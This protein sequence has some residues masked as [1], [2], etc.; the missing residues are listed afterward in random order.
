MINHVKYELSTNILTV[1]DQRKLPD[2]EI[3]LNCSNGEEVAIAIENLTV[4]GAPLIGVTAAYG[5]L[6]V[7]NNFL[8][9]G[10]DLKVI[11]DD[12]AKYMERLSKTRPTA[13]NL[14]WA[15]NEMKLIVNSNRSIDEINS[16]LLKRAIDIHEHD[17]ENNKKIGVFGAS[18][19]KN[20]KNILT[21]CNAGALA[22]GGYGTAVGV[23]RAV[24]DLN[25]VIH[26][27]VDE[28]RPVLQG[29]RLTA[30]ELYK[31]QIDHSVICDNMAASLM[32]K[33]KVDGIVIGAD[34]ITKNGDTANKIGSYSLAVLADYHK[35][36]FIVAAP[37]STIDFSLE[38]GSEIPIEER[39]PME[40]K[41]VGNRWLTP[42]KSNVFNPAF[43]VVPSNLITAIVTEL[44]ISEYPYSFKK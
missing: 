16:K 9:K 17:I 25:P 31:E 1:L 26:I 35:I 27:W 22:T 43:D 32:S 37:Q 21:H 13:V 4:R 33:G 2:E 12:L 11:Q 23:I 41:M 28:T 10:S 34:R 19:L 14:F 15:I 42:R 30:Y 38:Q 7:W 6:I 20:T 3:F 40:I 29:A 18:L 39:D 44:G 5:I 36:P 8:K 24:H